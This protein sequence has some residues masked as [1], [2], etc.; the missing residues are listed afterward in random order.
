MK[1]YPAESTWTVRIDPQEQGLAAQW[2]DHP[3]ESELRLRIPGAVQ[4]M[5]ELAAS[6]PGTSGLVN[7]YLGT[8]WLEGRVTLGPVAAEQRVW[9]RLG[10]LA[11]GAH[12]WLNGAYIGTHAAPPVE[13]SWEVT[14]H[15]RPDAENRITLALV[16]TKAS[17][18]G[19]LRFSSL[20]WSGVFR[21]VW[22]EVCGRSRLEDLWARPRESLDGLEL[23]GRLSS[24]LPVPETPTLRC[25]VRQAGQGTALFESEQ[26][27]TP[28]AEAFAMDVPL[29][30]APLWCPD[31]P[32][33]LDIRVELLV[34]GQLLHAREFRTGLKRLEAREG[35]LLLN[36]RPFLARGAGQEFFSPTL[37]PLT[38]KT[39]I[40]KRFQ[41]LKA[42]GFNFFRFHTHAP[43][44]EELEVADEIGLLL[45]SEISL[46]SNF[47]KTEPF[48]EGLEILRRHVLESRSHPSLAVYGLGNEGSQIL[49]SCERT[50]EEARR[51]YALLKQVAPDHPAMI[52]FGMQGEL[53]D[54][55]NDIESPHLWSHD[56]RWAYDGLSRVPWRLLSPLTRRAP[57]IVHEL[58]KF[59]VWPDPR[60]E[61]G[62]PGNGYKLPFGQQ[63]L[64]ALRAAGLEAHH[65]AIL[66]SSRSLSGLCHRNLIEQC[67]RQPGVDGYTVWTFFRTGARSGGL[68][69]DFG[70]Q[71]DHPPGVFASGCNAPTALL[72]DRD[73]D[74]RILRAGLVEILTPHLSLFGPEPQGVLSL[75]HELR[76]EDQVLLSGET[77][78]SAWIHGCN[79]PLPALRLAIPSLERPASASFQLW[80]E[81]NGKTL[82]QNQWDFWIFPP[83]VSFPPDLMVCDMRCVETER[84]L[85]ALIP[86]LVSFR[87]LDATLRGCRH[88][89]GADLAA[90]LADGPP[91]TWISDHWSESARQ[92]LR[93]GRT[94]VLLDTG[95]YPPDWYA[96]AQP[97][98]TDSFNIHLSYTN[99]RAGW[100]QGNIA[101]LLHPHPA[102][103]GFPH[104]GWCGPQFYGMIQYARP[105]R[106]QALQT[107]PGAEAPSVIVRSVPLLRPSSAMNAP[108]VQDPNAK[109]GPGGARELPITTEDRAYLAHTRVDGG[110]LL[111]SSLR[112][113]EDGAGPYLLSRLLSPPDA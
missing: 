89:T 94:V 32:A 5:K 2:A 109:R 35:K 44:R 75:R 73:L 95:H 28:G 27:L 53:P 112:F 18:M 40:R 17:L 13:G 57:C 8:V 72:I 11:P 9:L 106:T 34:K 47:G 37:L 76:T 6:Y 113:L 108:V 83:A 64:E 110:D 107:L 80:L 62:Y 4:S 39:L 56:F 68:A 81:E 96:R 22:M 48:E 58:G 43:T 102:L 101:T 45:V 7:G 66:R 15:A 46:V 70:E 100:D 59:G 54:L 87:D 60:E 74:R 67:R 55:P 41:C 86:G 38:D 103:G 42:H 91:F 84:R 92:V 3:L 63:G 99:F 85:K 20:N 19:G 88:W 21:P 10:G 61:N 36:G 14:A 105:L 25:R 111:V 23:S 104:D 52:A 78:V 49:V 98:D 82:A 29:P 65:A 90:I 1:R 51:A 12:L 16:E 69:D 24:P 71:S 97:S 33:L 79:Q 31:H 50:R 93:N 30:G 26:E 77:P